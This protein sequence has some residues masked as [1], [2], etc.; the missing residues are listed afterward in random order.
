MEKESI[1]VMNSKLL[2]SIELSKKKG[3]HG[4]NDIVNKLPEPKI[5]IEKFN[6]IREAFCLDKPATYTLNED[7][8]KEL[9]FKRNPHL[10]SVCKSLFAQD[11]NN[12]K[13]IIF[14]YLCFGYNN[15]KDL[16]YYNK[17][18]FDDENTE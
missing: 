2:K 16:Q 18:I 5:M 12:L 3:Y 6:H 1:D 11:Q 9:I 7:Q 10:K 15:F 8:Y 14:G 17:K 4:D 13:N